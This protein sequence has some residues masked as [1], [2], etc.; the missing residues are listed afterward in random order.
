MT[1]AGGLSATADAIVT[2][3]P[4]PYYPPQALPGKDQLIKL[5][6]N[7]ITLD[8]SNSKSFKVSHCPTALL[9]PN[10]HTHAHT[11]TNTQGELQYTWEMLKG[12]G[13]VD[14]KGT[15]T[16]N[17][18][19]LHFSSTG[20]YIF[21]LTVMD[22]TGQKS[23]ANVS[24]VVIPENNLPPVA[25]AGPD[26]TVVYPSTTTLLNGNHSTD[27]FRIDA[28]AWTQLTGP[29][30]LLLDGLN[31]SLL[32]V[33]GLHIDA[34][35]GSPT[36]YQFQLTVW[37]YHN[38]TNTS[39]VTITYRKGKASLEL[40]K[41]FNLFPVDPKIPPH[42]NAGGDVNITLPQNTIILNGSG[43][44]DDFGISSYQWVRSES[45]PAAGVSPHP[46]L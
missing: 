25:D 1:D 41:K 5:P 2:V 45:S 9:L 7:H 43:S 38:L 19:L 23:S 22:S 37:D 3:Q 42:A 31:S 16:P 6:N 46:S 32:Q 11:C 44:Y 4:E 26:Q 35:K 24:V 28:W 40:V 8:G 18:E 14:M 33:E 17:L 39:T 29:H 36:L 13:S 27:D 15:S 12:P 10:T 20:D 30:D 21:R 34:N